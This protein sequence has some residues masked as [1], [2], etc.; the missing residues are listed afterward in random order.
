MDVETKNRIR[1]QNYNLFLV[2]G[3]N[4]PDDLFNVSDSLFQ[5]L[6][7]FLKIVFI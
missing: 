4:I 3:Y 5:R 6:L 2:K 7:K 1:Y